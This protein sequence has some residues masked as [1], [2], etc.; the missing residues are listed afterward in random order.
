[1]LMPVVFANAKWRRAGVKPKA[2]KKCPRA[3]LALHTRVMR[4][5]MQ[6]RNHAETRGRCVKV[7]PLRR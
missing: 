7:P 3:L 5:G 1:M 2:E 6:K 4:V